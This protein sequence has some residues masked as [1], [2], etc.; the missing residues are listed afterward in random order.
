MEDGDAGQ[1]SLG[2]FSDKDSVA[3]CALD[4]VCVLTAA[5]VVEGNEDI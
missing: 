5:G 1:S 4:A 2:N 3:T